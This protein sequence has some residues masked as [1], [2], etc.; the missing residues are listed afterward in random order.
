MSAGLMSWS[1][2]ADKVV[3][4]STMATVAA[5]ND[6]AGSADVAVGS[7][8]VEVTRLESRSSSSAYIYTIFHYQSRLAACDLM[9]RYFR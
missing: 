4:D 1:L 9:F 7:S 2:S 5:R 6:G 3:L 8:L